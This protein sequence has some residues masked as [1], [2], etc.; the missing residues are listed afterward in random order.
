V[1][2]K[3]ASDEVLAEETARMSAN[4]LESSMKG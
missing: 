1:A 2:K 4:S 3:S